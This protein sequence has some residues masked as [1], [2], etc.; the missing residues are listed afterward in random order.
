MC[1]EE[2]Q[3][4]LAAWVAEAEAAMAQ[5][6]SL[7]ANVNVMADGYEGQTVS[8]VLHPPGYV[9]PLPEPEPEPEPMPP[10]EM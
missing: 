2:N 7:V 1:Q 9:A 6:A 10:M 4:V 8:V 3:E 5:K